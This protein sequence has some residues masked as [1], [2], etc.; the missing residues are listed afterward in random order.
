ML[1][2]QFGA[3]PN[4]VLHGVLIALGLFFVIPGLGILWFRSKGMID[5]F[6]IRLKEKRAKPVLLG[7]ACN[8]AAL[9]VI[10][11]VS[12]P[13]QPLIFAS[14]LAFFVAGLAI[15]FI[16]KRWKI[17]IHLT[18]YAA[19]VCALFAANFEWTSDLVGVLGMKYLSTWLSGA[20]IGGAPLLMWA[21]VHC[22]VHTLAQVLV[23]FFFGCVCHLAAYWIL[24][25]I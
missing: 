23:G 1:L 2:F 10:A 13:S 3:T 20:I 11:R 9:V 7:L 8:L 25:T 15:F 6:D 22:K 24:A 5:S 21:R 4:G 17:S 19:V 16:T 12:F 14:T 18:S